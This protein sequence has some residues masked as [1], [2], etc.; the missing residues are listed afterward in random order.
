V[1]WRLAVHDRLSAL[2]VLEGAL[3]RIVVWPYCLGA[4]FSR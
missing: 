1:V 4:T 3:R 2:D